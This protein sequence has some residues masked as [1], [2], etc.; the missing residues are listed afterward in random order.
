MRI[1]MNTQ[2]HQQE[3]ECVNLH[4]HA[5]SAFCIN[6]FI[7]V[8]VKDSYMR[9]ERFGWYTHIF[10][11]DPSNVVIKHLWQSYVMKAGCLTVSFTYKINLM[12]TVWV[13][14]LLF[15]IM[16]CWVCVEDECR[17]LTVWGVKLLCSLAVRQLWLGGCC[18]SV[19]LCSVQTRHITDAL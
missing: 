19:S 12:S 9:S 3:Y 10:C 8:Q 17:S 4:S 18:H 15:W 13:L 2:T 7:S 1:M 5:L 6:I 14:L 16:E 11:S